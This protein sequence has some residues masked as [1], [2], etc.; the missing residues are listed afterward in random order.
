MQELDR[1]R[2]ERD[3]L[4]DLPGWKLFQR[5]WLNNA[6]WP[7]KSDDQVRREQ[8]G[9]DSPMRLGGRLWGW[10]S[11]RDDISPEARYEYCW[12]L[13]VVGRPLRFPDEAELPKTSAMGFY[14]YCPYCEIATDEI[15]SEE[16]PTC[17]RQLL[18]GRWAE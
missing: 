13:E 17:G 10:L 12:T 6:T 11:D 8:A 1:F 16:C 14:Q 3:Q 4:R 5:K 15:G 7:T 9:R 2:A 18:Y